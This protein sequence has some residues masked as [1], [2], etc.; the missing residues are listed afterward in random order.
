MLAFF[1]TIHPSIKDMSET[2][3]IKIRERKE[4]I[5]NIALIGLILLAI[6]LR[7]KNLGLSLFFG[8]EEHYIFISNYILKTFPYFG[9]FFLHTSNFPAI[10]TLGPMPFYIFALPLI[11][12][13]NPLSVTFLI[14]LLN[15]LAVILCYGFVKV[16]FNRRIALITTALFAVSPWAVA[17]ARKIWNPYMV[18]PFIIL[19]YY[20]FFLALFKNKQKYLILSFIISAFSIQLC[21]ICY[22]LIPS[23]ILGIY[24]FRRQLRKRYTIIGAACFI[25]LYLPQFFLESK[26]DFYLYNWLTDRLLTS[27][28]K[29]MINA[30]AIHLKPISYFNSVSKVSYWLG[31]ILFIL[32]LIVIIKRYLLSY[33]LARKERSKEY[34]KY[35]LVL[36]WTFAPLLLLMLFRQNCDPTDHHYSIS[37]FPA[38]FIIMAIGLDYIAKQKIFKSF[39]LKPFVFI[40]VIT[41]ISLQSIGIIRLHRQIDREGIIYETWPYGDV[42]LRYKIN[43]VKYIIHDSSNN[44]LIFEKNIHTLIAIA[45]DY[46]ALVGYWYL[47]NFFSKEVGEKEIPPKYFD[48]PVHYIIIHKE[49]NNLDSLKRWASLNNVEIYVNDINANLKVIKINSE[50]NF[51]KFKSAFGVADTEYEYYTKDTRFQ[52]LF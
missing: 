30:L 41:I 38:Q 26:S 7:V 45:P 46:Y 6:Y 19:F 5:A 36:S 44:K 27:N 3:L 18:L 25:L 17:C 14:A 23:L 52:N 4:L 49:R 13:K 48:V 22:A 12:S 29:E 31:I 51:N 28:F 11:I 32:G 21:Q 16:F 42:P 47:F 37:I 9:S 34:L 35:I 2:I 43:I 15:I 39:S 10:A 20:T 24:F 40:I 50:E 8:E 33:I 1:Q